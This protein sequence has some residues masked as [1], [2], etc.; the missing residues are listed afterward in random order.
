MKCKCPAGFRN[1]EESHMYRVRYNRICTILFY[2]DGKCV[3]IFSRCRG[4]PLP[5]SLRPRRPRAFR[6]LHLR[7]RFHRSR[8]RSST[9]QNFE[10]R[11][12]P[13]DSV[14]RPEMPGRNRSSLRSAFRSEPC[15]P[16][17]F[18]FGAPPPRLDRSRC[19]RTCTILFSDDGKCVSIFSRCRGFPLPRSLRAA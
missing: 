11:R 5:R 16:G 4:F 3:S 17:D 18:A 2:D 19:N 14:T 12:S 10:S 13:H 8:T 1:P 6:I 9:K 15:A 7:R